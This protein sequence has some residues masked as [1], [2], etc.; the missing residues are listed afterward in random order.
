MGLRERGRFTVPGWGVFSAIWEADKLLYLNLEEV[1]T[2]RQL[3]PAP[4]GQAR[5]PFLQEVE[6]QVAAY[7][8]GRLQTFDLPHQL[9]QTPPFRSQLLRAAQDIPYGQ[10]LSYGGLAARCGR[11]RAARAAGSAMCHCPLFLL[12]PCHRVIAAGRK[13]GGF[14]S[15]PELKRRLL[16][17][18]GVEVTPDDLVRL[19]SGQ[20][21]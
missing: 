1:H 6:A 7:L 13:L 11:P 8:A 17:L 5:P 15:H 9:P 21:E 14:G 19:P 4:V 18:E 12:I 16:A 2:A 20:E 10:V 3:K